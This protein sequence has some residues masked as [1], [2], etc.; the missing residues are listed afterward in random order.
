MAKTRDLFGVKIISLN[1]MVAI[2][3]IK[4]NVQRVDVPTK[5]NANELL[6]LQGNF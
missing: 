3:L 6:T 2:F 1:K 4:R 5:C